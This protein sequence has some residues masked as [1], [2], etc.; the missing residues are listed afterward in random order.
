MRLLSVRASNSRFRGY[1]TPS[2]KHYE[3]RVNIRVIVLPL[4][5]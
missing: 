3:V 5:A 4:S 2:K 1:F